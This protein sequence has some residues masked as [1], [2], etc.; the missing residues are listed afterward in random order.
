MWPWLLM[1][2]VALTL[3]VALHSVRQSEQR[4]ADT[5]SPAAPAQ[6]EAPED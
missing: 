5:P 3:Y 2:L 6:I 4:T 1:P